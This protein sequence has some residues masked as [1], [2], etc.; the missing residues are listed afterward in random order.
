MTNADWV[1]GKFGNALDFDGSNDYVE[2]PES[3]G[4]LASITVSAWLK[5][6]DL[7]WDTIASK[8]PAGNSGERDGMRASPVQESSDSDWVDRMVRIMKSILPY[9]SFQPVPGCTM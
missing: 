3:V 9:P 5:P 7:A 4:N 1:A 6:S 2:L 8:V